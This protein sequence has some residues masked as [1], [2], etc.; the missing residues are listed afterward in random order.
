MNPIALCFASGESLFSGAA[1]LA[2]AIAISHFIRGKWLSLARNVL[3]LIALTM[4]V[5]AALAFAWLVDVIFLSAFSFWFIAWDLAVR[6]Q[7]VR[8]ATASLLAGMLLV[9]PALE[10][11]HRALPVISG[12]PSD[13]LV[14]IGDSVSSGI[15]PNVPA[16]PAFMQKM[17]GLR[18]INLARPGAYTQDGLD[19]ADKIELND[20]LIL[21]EIAG[22]DLITGVPAREFG[23]SL[24]QLLRKVAAPNRTVVMFEL[25]L[26][27]WR[28]SYGQVQ[29][30]LANKYRVFLIPKRYFTSVIWGRQATSDGLHLL[31]EGERRMA[32][33][34]ASLLSPLIK[35]VH[36]PLEPESQIPK[37]IL[38]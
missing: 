27:P 11:R 3:S 36:I 10:W 26:L 19:M 6:L 20:R 18:V 5:M 29:R 28:I 35:P 31:P 33:L 32:I 8:V 4:I 23:R 34:V 17:T 30:Q 12:L 13:H 2:L 1:L 15:D 38:L 14:V 16:W 24:E 7:V 37:F 9:F 22:N 25:P 21:I